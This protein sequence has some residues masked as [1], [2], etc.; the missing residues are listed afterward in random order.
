MTSS[1]TD[2]PINLCLTGCI[3]NIAWLVMSITSFY[4]CKPTDAYIDIKTS[5]EPPLPK[6]SL[7][8]SAQMIFQVSDMPATLCYIVN[9]QEWYLTK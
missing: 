6:S 7:I 9:T 5:L 2:N 3:A 1:S 8:T 4:S